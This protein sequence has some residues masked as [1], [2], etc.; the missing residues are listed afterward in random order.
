MVSERYCLG[1]KIQGRKGKEVRYEQHL[2]CSGEEM[3]TGLAV[4]LKLMNMIDR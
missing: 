4:C 3:G 2:W 1:A